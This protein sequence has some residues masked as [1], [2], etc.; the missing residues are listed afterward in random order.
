[1]TTPFDP[2][3]PKHVREPVW[4]EEAPHVARPRLEESLS[5]D[6]AVVGAGI[7]GLT[8]AYLLSQDGYDVVVLEADRVCGGVTGHTTA[9]VSVL[10]GLI[11]RRLMQTWGEDRASIYA[12]SGLR[13]MQAIDSWASGFGVGDAIERAPAYTY[14]DDPSL[15]EDIDFEA[16]A[17][18]ACGLDA[19]VVTDTELPFPVAGAVRLDDQM[20]I[21]PRRYL[22]AMT[23][24][25]EAAGGR[26]FEGARIASLE[27][28]ERPRIGTD[29]GYIVEAGHVVVATNM[30]IFDRGLFFTKVHPHRSYVLTVRSEHASIGGMYI[31]HGGSTRS[32]RSV[33]FGDSRL[34]MVGGAGHRTGT[35]ERSDLRYEEL[36]NFA[37]DAFGSSEV[38]HAWSTQD[39][40][41]VD[42]L[43]FVGRLRHNTDN[44]L[45][46]T[47]FNKWGMTN[48]TI[49]AETLA[50]MVAGRTDPSEGIFDSKRFVPKDAVLDFLKGNAVAA[51]YMVGDR[52]D[53]RSRGSAD[54]LAPGEGGVFR[55]GMNHVAVFR[56]SNGTV[57][58]HS[59]TCSHLG[60][61]V[62]WNQ[63]EASF[64]C[65][66]HGS[67]F[68]RFGKVIQGPATKDLSP[69]D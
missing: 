21:H 6:V 49:A 28:G 51:G 35:E 66:C 40:L 60:C 41:P 5:C 36:R 39:C 29:T 22:L 33:P 7:A 11:Y 30:P 64:D 20:Q 69:H 50:A 59:A 2:G 19:E 31:N 68:D 57:H 53:P 18:R 46:A 16:K 45:V 1:M 34:L 37:S 43:P 63:G 42:H 65:P 26:I 55:E 58:R 24:R 4:F 62:H 17:A 15:T 54:D 47:G 61:V 52:V 67:R 23:E 44:V 9:K 27:E 14:T 12:S 56:D 38:V 13:A 32:I 10:Q 25:I 8:T 48:G 3:K